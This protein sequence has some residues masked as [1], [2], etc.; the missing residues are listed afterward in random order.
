MKKIF[1]LCL[2]VLFSLSFCLAAIDVIPTSISLEGQKDD[3]V[4][5]NFD[6]QNTG[7]ENITVFKEDFKF[8][9][10]EFKDNDDDPISLLFSDLGLIEPGATIT[11]KLTATISNRMDTGVYDDTINLT[12]NSDYDTFK[13]EVFVV[14]SICDEGKVGDLGIDDLDIKNHDDDFYPGDIITAVV[15]IANDGD[16]DISD[17][18]VEAV[19]YDLTDG[20]ELTDWIRSDNFDLDSG[21]NENN[22]ELELEIPSDVEVDDNIVVFARVYED[23]NEDENCW[24]KQYDDFDIKRMSHD[25]YLKINSIIP[26]I[27]DCGESFDVNTFVYNIGKKDETGVYIKVKDSTGKLLGQTTPFDL[28]SSDEDTKIITVNVPKDIDPKDYSLEVIVYYDNGDSTKSKFSTIKV[29]CEQLNVAPV[30]DAGAS[31][32]VSKGTTVSLDGSGSSDADGDTLTYSWAQESGIKV[33]I[34]NPTSK[35]ASVKLDQADTYVFK[36]TVTDGKATSTDTVTIT[37]NTSGTATVTG[38]TV[39]STTSFLGKVFKK[40]NIV[41]GFWVM[42]IIVLF[43][44]AIYFVKLIIFPGRGAREF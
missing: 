29:T 7:T 26:S 16:D 24:Y 21:D 42:G 23:G 22:I 4:T 2:A 27:V 20:S 40:E 33:N 12:I 43:I 39:Y 17:I 13:L 5:Y 32:T 9:L 31:K 15:D 19:L 38:N 10:N 3:V 35:I 44:L 6:I 28:D 11:A 1:M 41:T 18:Y 25:I 36:L 34:E 30:A 37:T 8:R 14:P